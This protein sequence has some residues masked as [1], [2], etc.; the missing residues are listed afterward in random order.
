[1]ARFSPELL[2]SIREFGS[3]LSAPQ[4]SSGRMLTGAQPTT[5]GGILARNVGA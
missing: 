4:T 5:L 2:R 1:M 3:S